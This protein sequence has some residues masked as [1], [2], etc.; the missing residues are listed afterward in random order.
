MIEK[1]D[2]DFIYRL[3]GVNIHRGSAQHGHY[4]SLININR[5]TKEKDG[6][7]WGKVE[8]DIWKAFDDDEVRF[9]SYSNIAGESY[10]GD[11]TGLKQ[12]EIDTFLSE[13]S[14][15]GKSSY[16]LVYERKTKG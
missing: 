2:D 8:E 13:G 16:M 4:W 3:V 10:G 1:E 6:P 11:A 9:Q 14:A 7:V 15:Y 5:G 12:D